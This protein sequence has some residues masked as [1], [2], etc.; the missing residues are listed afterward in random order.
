MQMPERVQ[1]DEATRSETFGRFVL[2]PLEEG[3]GTTIGNAFRRVLLASIPG[4]AIAAI[5]IDGVLHEFQTITG[6]TEDMAEIILNLK[7]IR[8][9][10]IDKKTNK[11]AFDVRGAGDFTGAN[12]QAATGY[13]PLPKPTRD[14][15]LRTRGCTQSWRDVP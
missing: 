4:C 8:L 13:Q 3:Y 6:V 12:I 14:G 5:K 1:L 15:A 7:E 10:Q 9:K 2:Q 11:I